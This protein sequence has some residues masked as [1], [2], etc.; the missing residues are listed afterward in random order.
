MNYHFIRDYEELTDPRNARVTTT[1][2]Y[3]PEMDIMT[4]ATISRLELL[5]DGAAMETSWA[6]MPGW[7]APTH[8][9]EPEAGT[10][11]GRLVTH[12]LESA[13]LGTRHTMR[14]Y[15]P[16]AYDVRGDQTRYPVAYYHNGGGAIARGNLPTS[17]DNLIGRSVRPLVAVFIEP[18]AGG[19]QYADIW[20]NEIIPFIDTTYR[21]LDSREGRA[22]VGGGFAG[23]T[24]L[25][26]A[27]QRTDLV[28]KV[29]ALSPANLVFAGP[30]A[31]LQ[32]LVDAA[33]G[34]SMDLYMEW[35]LYDAR[36]PHEN[37]DLRDAVEDFMDFLVDRGYT[38]AGGAVPDGTG[39]SSWKNRTDL[40]LRSLFPLDDGRQ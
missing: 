35:G 7:R 22:S 9:A 31:A 28:E 2:V 3:G 37:W 19:A 15:L 5:P 38:V 27:F 29:G 11:R 14:V 40:V 8:L 34:R 16:A 20:A 1:A 4:P 30:T 36:A 6:S 12:E 10:A 18:I 23:Y 33:E 21:T 25:S 13:V 39:W 26:L 17:L 24:A 32:R